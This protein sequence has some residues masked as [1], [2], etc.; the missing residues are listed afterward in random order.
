MRLEAA[1]SNIT[2]NALVR[3]ALSAVLTYSLLMSAN[4]A[5]KLEQ[6][7]SVQPPPEQPTMQFAYASYIY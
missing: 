3:F 1:T 4:L 6:L 2:H 7:D 5:L